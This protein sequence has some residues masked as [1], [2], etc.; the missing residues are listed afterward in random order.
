MIFLH[1]MHSSVYI[2]NALEHL[3]DKELNFVINNQKE[4]YFH[5]KL[6]QQQKLTQQNKL[7]QKGRLLLTIRKQ[8]R[9]RRLQPWQIQFLLPQIF[10]LTAKLLQQQKYNHLYPQQHMKLKI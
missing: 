2:I 5:K 10:R 8:Q 4:Q 9:R 1:K 7:Q 6:Q 3:L